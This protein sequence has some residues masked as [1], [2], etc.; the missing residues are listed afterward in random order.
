MI[1]LITADFAPAAH[2]QQEP[3]FESTHE[4]LSFAYRFNRLQYP[5]T[6]I[7]KLMRGPELGSGRG[8]V[9]MDGAA[10]AG[11]VL[12]VVGR[13]DKLHRLALQARFGNRWQDCPC[14][15]A[16][17]PTREFAESIEGLANWAI[18]ATV[19]HMR[20][21]R[22][23]VQKYYTGSIKIGDIADAASINRKTAGDHWAII[24]ARLDKLEA[25]AHDCIDAALKGAGMVGY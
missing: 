11:M 19:S 22:L 25:Q 6:L 17:Q 13:L 5:T 2:G 23:L 16:E 20:A 24:K 18:P 4:A 10:Q 12:A 14:C 3:I 8:L 21:R 1:A 9:G 7:G 15:G